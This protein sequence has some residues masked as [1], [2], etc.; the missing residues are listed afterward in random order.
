VNPLS[1]EIY[2][3]LGMALITVIPRVL[4]A[5]ISQHSLKS[6]VL[7]RFLS[8]IPLAA[9]GALIVPGIFTVG[10][11]WGIGLAGGLL[12]L[13]LAARKANIMVNILLSTGF[14]TL[15]LLII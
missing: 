5:L 12:S 2:T 14:V 8:S 7:Q 13:L 6:K 3:V 10:D 1:N 9:L 11:S 15:L 4:P